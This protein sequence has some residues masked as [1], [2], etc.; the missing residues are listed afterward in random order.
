MKKKPIEGICKL[1]N[2]KQ[3]LIN[4]HIIPKFIHKKIDPKRNEPYVVYENMKV[5]EKNDLGVK[6]YLLCEN[7][8]N[9]I[10]HKYEDYFNHVWYENSVLPYKLNHKEVV[11]IDISYKPFLLFHLSIFW[12]M[13]VSSHST[14]RHIN[15]GKKHNDQIRRIL[16]NDDISNTNYKIIVK[17]IEM[18]NGLFDKI[19]TQPIP[20]KKNSH[21][22]YS[23]IYAGCEIIL[24]ISSHDCKEFD[25]FTIKNNKCNVFIV[26]YK[27]INQIIDVSNIL[28]NIGKK[29]TK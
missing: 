17:V 21:N 27:K 4:S 5:S 20:Y 16:L 29:S 26:N 6:E 19:I 8:D 24:K 25:K 12:R 14:F 2:S 22:I 15:F 13:S 11:S 7:C 28:N 9:V 3:M 1:C 10:L 23:A 18:D